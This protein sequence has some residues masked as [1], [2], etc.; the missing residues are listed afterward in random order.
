MQPKRKSKPTPYRGRLTP[1]SAS[2]G[3]HAA[4]ANSSRLIED[5]EMLSNNGRYPSACSIAALAI[6]EM[7]KPAIIRKI[8]IAESPQ[9]IARGWKLFSS[10]H[11][12][13]APWIVPHLIR[14]DLGTYEDFVEEFMRNRDPLLLDS[15]KQISIYCGCYGKSHWSSPTEVIEADQSELLIETAKILQFSGQL[16]PLDSE[17]GIRLW[18]EH[19]AGCFSVGYV[20]A[21]NKIVEFFA[22][23][24]DHGLLPE[25]K[26]PQTV[27]F[28]FMTTALILSDGEIEE[29]KRIF[30]IS[31]TEDI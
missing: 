29:Q 2:K 15:L 14:E 3:I 31:F 7:S 26:I 20:T 25:N 6:E 8:V 9:E 16:S 28:D 1:E 12:K 30:G 21:N 5:A 24:A 19:M 11:D 18:K 10:H 13:G 27:A 4:K 17:D 23:A 22:K